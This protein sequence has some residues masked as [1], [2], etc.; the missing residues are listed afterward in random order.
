MAYIFLCLDMRL[1]MRLSWLTLSEPWPEAVVAIANNIAKNKK[2]FM[3][4]KVLECKNTIFSDF[5]RKL[6]LCGKIV[7]DE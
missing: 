5:K 6:Y 7:H 2:R 3:T 1:S 4:M